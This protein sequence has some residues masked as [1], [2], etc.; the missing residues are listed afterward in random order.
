MRCALLSLAG[1]SLARVGKFEQAE[2]MF[3]QA[4]VLAE[5]SQR[6]FLDYTG[7]FGPSR[8]LTMRYPAAIEVT[9]AAI[10][11]RG[12]PAPW[13]RVNLL[14]TLPLCQLYA[15][16]SRAAWQTLEALEP[17]AER[18]G[19]LGALYF[20]ARARAFK[21]SL[22]GAD[23]ETFERWAKRD[24]ALY[25][26]IAESSVEGHAMLAFSNF[27]QGKW[28][29]AEAGFAELEKRVGAHVDY[30]RGCGAAGLLLC[31]GYL[32]RASSVQELF[33]KRAVDLPIAGQPNTQGSWSLMF[34]GVEA[35]AQIEDYERSG[36][37]YPLALE[38]CSSGAVLRWL[39]DGLVT[40]VA[41][42]AAFAAG[43]YTAAEKHFEAALLQAEELPHVIERA[44]IRRWFAKMLRKRS[45]NSDEARATALLCEAMKRYEQLG[46]PRHSQLCR[47]EQW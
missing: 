35:L 8:F 42:I 25:A 47:E 9:E 31:H 6:S 19:H 40:S 23:F 18:V 20:A 39:G 17:Q 2:Q 34:A 21:A 22:E 24:I 4:A 37:L 30:V 11:T 43:H 13:L 14:S 12:E 3:K 32:G 15:G 16:Q 5:E 46:M 26:Q 28:R 7:A 29:E 33:S 10:A 38:A 27:W 1:V 36:A 44:N 41:G 45:E